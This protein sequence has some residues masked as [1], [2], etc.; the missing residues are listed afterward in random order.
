MFFVSLIVPSVSPSSTP[1]SGADTLGKDMYT[2]N[3]E[4]VRK[5]NSTTWASR[6]NKRMERVTTCTYIP[7]H[8]TF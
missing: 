8:F 7:L 6:A 4:C 2:Y 1:G 3:V 5:S